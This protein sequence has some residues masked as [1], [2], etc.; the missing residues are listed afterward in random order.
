MNPER[1]DVGIAIRSAF[2][3]RGT[4]QKF[5]LFALII[6]SILLILVDSFNIKPVNFIRSFVKDTIYRGSLIISTPSRN[7]DI[8]KTYI[9]DHINLY[10]NYKN[11]ERENQK[12]K[13]DISKT[14]FSED[15]TF[16][17]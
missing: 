12:M 3:V 6:L 15:N 4:K 11:L 13:G 10:E 5:S 7:F 2:L 8:L 14:D 16:N 9:S 1:E 17:L